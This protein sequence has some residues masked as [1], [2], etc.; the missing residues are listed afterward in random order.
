MTTRKII[1]MATMLLLA[2]CFSTA[3]GQPPGRPRKAPWPRPDEGRPQWNG[4]TPASKTVEGKLVVETWDKSRACAGTTLFTDG[5]DPNKP[6]VVEV[7]MAGRVVWEYVLPERYRPYTHPG[8][9]AERL[10]NGNTLIVLPRKGL[11]EVDPS[12]RIVWSHD[13]PK[14]SHDADRLP[15]GNT[16]YV[17]GHE[18]KAGD[19]VVKE[20]DAR[21]RLVWS[22]SAKDAF[23]KEPYKGIS[24]QGWTHANAVTRL[25]NGNTLVSLRNFFLTVEV[26]PAGKVVW[27]YDWSRFGRETYPHEPE[28]QPGGTLVCCI[29]K[30]APCEV[31][32]I[33]RATGETVWTYDHPNLRTTRDA[34]RLPNG[35]TLLVSVLQA[36]G[37][38][39]ILEVTPVGE[40]VWQL[41]LDG[42]R[43]GRSPGFFYKAQRIPAE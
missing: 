34:D 40:I 35:N 6:R 33:D 38:S 19:A 32:E 1:R 5:H 10:E 21:G 30:D 28:L 29:Q 7:D 25:D 15:N 2:A 26:D 16:I 17:F 13:D 36:E 3:E 11:I 14:I 20:V 37:E 22:W 4:T 24:N 41:T 43:L 12:G 42:A 27:S 31:A 18:D 8:F 9:D 39:T 23:Y